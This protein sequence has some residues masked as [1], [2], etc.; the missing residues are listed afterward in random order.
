MIIIFPRAQLW[1]HLFRQKFHGDVNTNNYTESFNNVLKHH[2][3]ILRNDKSVFSL[4]Q[5]LLQHVFP[6]QEREYTE[7]SARQTKDHRLPR[8]PLPSFLLNRPKPVVSA[9]L[10]SIEKAKAI[11]IST[12]TEEDSV[13]GT[14]SVKSKNGEYLVTI[15]EGKCTCPYYTLRQIPCKHMFC[16]LQNFNWTWDDFPSSCTECTHMILDRELDMCISQGDVLAEHQDI[17]PNDDSIP[18]AGHSSTSIPPHQTAGS[19]LF[20]LQKQLRDELAKCT[21]AVFMIDDIRTLETL[22]ERIHDIHTELVSAVSLSQTEG[23]TT[24]KHLMKEEVVESRKRSRLITRANQISKK[25]SKMKR[26]TRGECPI[27]TKRAR[28]VQRDDPLQAAAHASVGRPKGKKCDVAKS[29]TGTYIFH[30]TYEML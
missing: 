25:Y 4:V 5:L 14:Y 7:L 21:A 17:P 30:Y 12:I 11:D 15:K 28:P 13:K 24:M 16:I 29:V 22:K 20:C 6:D 19:K 26:K 18:F 2:Y 1:C 8:D 23:L 3:F 10:L 27:S 9:C